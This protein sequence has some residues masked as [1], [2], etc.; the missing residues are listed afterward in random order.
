MH[1]AGAL[2]AG[3]LKTGA[4]IFCFRSLDVH[5][6][7]EFR[8]G[9]VDNEQNELPFYPDRKVLRPRRCSQSTFPHDVYKYIA[10]RI[11]FLQKS[12]LSYKNQFIFI[13][14]ASKMML[15]F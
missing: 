5:K 3:V 15:L 9:L 13:T 11:I 6:N 10:K 8:K 7:N 2:K 12:I 1:K 4:C 14:L